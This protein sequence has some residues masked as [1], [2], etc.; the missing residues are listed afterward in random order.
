MGLFSKIKGT[1]ALCGKEVLHIGKGEFA[2]EDCKEQ[3]KIQGYLSYSTVAMGQELPVVG[4]DDYLRHRDAILDKYRINSDTEE[5]LDDFYG[6][7][8]GAIR[9]K[10]FYVTMGFFDYIVIDKADIFGIAYTEEPNFEIP[11]DVCYRIV[12]FTNDP[13]VPMFAVVSSCKKGFLKRA[14]KAGMEEMLQ[15]VSAECNH[16]T[17]PICEMK[18]LKKMVKSEGTVRGNI[19]LKTMLK[20]IDNARAGI[21]LFDVVKNIENSRSVQDN[22]PSPELVAWMAGYGYVWYGTSL[23]ME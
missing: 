15:Q 17:Y 23:Y 13:Y 16:L 22:L 10:H 8:I 14:D 7:E 2:C 19:E 9:A 21:A 3:R 4:Y 12:F 18:E 5:K 6:S 11:G 1:C 20:E